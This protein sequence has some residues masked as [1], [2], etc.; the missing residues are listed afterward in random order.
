MA[1]KII[2]R[3][4]A[5][6]GI[7]RLLPA[8]ANEI[9]LSDVQSLLM[10]AYQARTANFGESDLRRAA[11]RSLV[12]SSKVDARLLNQFDRTAYEVASEFE[13]VELSPVGPL[14]MNHV[15]GGIDQNNVLTTIRNAEV[16]GDP[17]TALALECWR[18]RQNQARPRPRNGSLV[19]QSTSGAHATVRPAGL[20]AALPIVSSCLGRP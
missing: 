6:T 20:Y 2:E 14:G 10:H 9:A 15:L 12:A 17:T 13:A 7:P 18:R 1:S 11:E 4:S 8:L 5:E 3:V 19:L 16:L